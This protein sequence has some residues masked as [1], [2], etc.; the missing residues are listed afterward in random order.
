MRQSDQHV[1]IWTPLRVITEVEKQVNSQSY[2]S[3]K[4]VV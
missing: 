3:I 2:K 4:I 1:W